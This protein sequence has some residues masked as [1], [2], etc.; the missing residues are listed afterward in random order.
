MLNNQMIYGN[1]IAFEPSPH[2]D[3]VG[4]HVG[5]KDGNFHGVSYGIYP[6]VD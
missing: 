2:D 4:F 5:E 3:M 1:F 6:P